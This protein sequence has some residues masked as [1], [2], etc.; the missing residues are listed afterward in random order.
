MLEAYR[1]LAQATDYPFHIGVTEAGTVKRGSI[2]S[3]V[4]IGALLADGI[5]DTIRVSLAADPAEEI[6]VQ[7]EIL[8]SL[9]LYEKGAEFIVCPTCGRTKIPVAAIAEKVEA[10]WKSWIFRKKSKLQLWAV[11]S[12][13]PARRERRISA[14]RAATASA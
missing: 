14:L 1:K 13:V 10:Q 5:G 9:G 12:T 3:A 7:K 2:K 4:G 6:F 11:L 8:R